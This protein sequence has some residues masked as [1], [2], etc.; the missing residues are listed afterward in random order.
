[1]NNLG[2]L[3][4]KKKKSSLNFSLTNR[5]SCLI[6]QRVFASK[7]EKFGLINNMAILAS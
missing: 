1:M 5:T 3:F 4:I 2:M 7:N 6:K